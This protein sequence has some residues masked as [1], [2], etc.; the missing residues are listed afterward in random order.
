MGSTGSKVMGCWGLAGAQQIVST[1]GFA[2]QEVQDVAV[3]PHPGVLGTLPNV[4][5]AC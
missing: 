1:V 5:Q 3:P 4:S 2:L